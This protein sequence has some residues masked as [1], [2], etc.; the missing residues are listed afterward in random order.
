MTRRN[1]L[2]KRGSEEG[3]A[4]QFQEIGNSGIGINHE[5]EIP[6]EEDQLVDMGAGSH[7]ER[8]SISNGDQLPNKAD[9]N[10]K[11]KRSSESGSSEKKWIC[12]GNTLW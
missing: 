4:S 10:I 11:P 9:S 12:A 7:V 8:G 2:K 1:I 6:R 3:F 5:N